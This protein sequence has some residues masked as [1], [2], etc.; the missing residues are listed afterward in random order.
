MNTLKIHILSLGLLLFGL[1]GCAVTD[2]DR[3]ADFSDYQTYAWGKSEV[4]VT[5]PLYESDLINKK[6]RST[7]E[8]EFAKRGIIKNENNPDFLVSYHTYTEKKEQV[9]GGYG[10]PYYGY[11]FSPFRFYPFAYGFG[12]PYYWMRPESKTQYTEGTLIIDIID[13]ASDALVWRGS[14]RGNV[15]DAAGLKKQIEKGIKAIMKKYPVSPD[16]PL[17]IGNDSETIS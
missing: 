6:I 3:S 16:A 14:V 8:S 4:K 9:S 1:A 11:G 12:Y 10:Y 17:N 7:V 2:I 15:D 5:N 13:R